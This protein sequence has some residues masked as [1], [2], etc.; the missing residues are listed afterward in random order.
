MLGGA[1]KIFVAHL[2]GSMREPLTK[3]DVIGITVG[4]PPWYRE[5]LTLLGPSAGRQVPNP[6]KRYSDVARAGWIIG[7]GLSDVEALEAAPRFKLLGEKPMKRLHDIL[8]DKI[9]PAFPEES[10][11]SVLAAVTHMM[12]NHT[13]SGAIIRLRD[14]NGNWVDNRTEVKRFSPENAEFAM[15]LFNTPPTVPLTDGE[16]TRLR[17]ILLQV[18][19]T[20]FEGACEIAQAFKNMSWCEDDLP[21]EYKRFMGV[22]RPGGYGWPWELRDQKQMIYLEDCIGSTF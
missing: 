22:G 19:S 1:E 7:I 18:L 16:V 17:P 9:L 21:E 3:G 5:T 2:D 11:R 12:V 13:D 6:I 8:N 10:I 4:F 14:E 20:A 15:A